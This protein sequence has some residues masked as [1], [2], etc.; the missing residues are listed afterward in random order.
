MPFA[1]QAE[2]HGVVPASQQQL[3]VGSVHVPLQHPFPQ[4]VYPAAHPH[5]PVDASR[6]AIPAEQHLGPHEVVPDGQV[7]A[8]ARKG[9]NSTAPTVAPTLAPIALRAVRRLRGAAIARARSSN[10]RSVTA[11]SYP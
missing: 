10:P 6:Q 9:F 3:L 5:F 7:A 2:P 1:Q 11:S 8:S 4:A